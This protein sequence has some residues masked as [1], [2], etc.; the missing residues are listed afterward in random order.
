[1]RLMHNMQSMNVLRNYNQH[2]VKNGS[3]LEKISSGVKI[4]SSKD[5]PIKLGQSETIRMQ[6]RGL[7]AAERNLQDGVSM[8][9][10]ADSAMSSV[11]E[12]L[13]RMK[14][15]AVQAS[16]D[17]Y[18]D[19]DKA[20]IQNEIEQ[21]KGYIDQTANNTEFNGM[22]ILKNENVVDNDYPYKE[23]MQSGANVADQMA[24]PMFNISTSVLKIDE[25]DVTK[26]DKIDEALGSID[27]AISTVSSIRSK[28]GA[29]QQRLETSAENLMQNNEA[30][31]K[32]DSNLRDAD[33][34]LEMAEFSRTSILRDTATAILTQ[35]N[36]F[37]Q[38]VLRILENVRK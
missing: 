4:N 25:V 22:K 20:V 23:Y 5:N 35:T 8:I 32:A 7:Q 30:L 21:L 13:I 37:P 3:S 14:E 12:T 24:I 27:S 10:T 28:Y 29:I 33:L 6:I 16:N 15:L 38:D 11:G 17:T 36:N 2:L 26:P 9:Q 18:S 1:M 19:E 31:E 34:A